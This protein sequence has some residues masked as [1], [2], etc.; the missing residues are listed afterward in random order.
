MKNLLYLINVI[1]T[2]SALFTNV[3]TKQTKISEN[4]SVVENSIEHHLKANTHTINNYSTKTFSREIVVQQDTVIK[5]TKDS[6]KGKKEMKEAP[7]HKSPDQEEID[8]IK[9]GKGKFKKEYSKS[10]K[11]SRKKL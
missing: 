9:K 2:S 5:N 8:S 4:Q 6:S 10:K 11:Q 7:K 3:Y 1:L